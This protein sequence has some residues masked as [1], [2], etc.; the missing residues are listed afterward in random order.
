MPG[1]TE[2]CTKR[3]YDGE[4]CVTCILPEFNSFKLNQKSGLSGRK[5][6][7]HAAAQR[8][9]RK[10]HRPVLT[11]FRQGGRAG[12]GAGDG[13]GR[14]V[15]P[16][17]HPAQAAAAG[18]APGSG[19]QRK[20]PLSWGAELKPWPLQ[21]WPLPP[22]SA[23]PV[24]CSPA[25]PDTEPREGGIRVTCGWFSKD[26]QRGG[27]GLCLPSVVSLRLAWRPPSVQKPGGNQLPRA[28]MGKV[29]IKPRRPVPCEH[30]CPSGNRHPDRGGPPCSAQLRCSLAGSCRTE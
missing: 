6:L 21:R 24:P 3:G 26:T 7:T 22:R 11:G 20:R 28:V 30:L 13:R 16:R 12:T 1:A 15:L 29:S 27:E 2:P 8:A 5:S 19:V 4:F 25:S 9:P 18:W 23:T 14:W 17:L 10:V